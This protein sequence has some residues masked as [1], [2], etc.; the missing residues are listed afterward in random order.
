MSMRSGLTV[1]MAKSNRNRFM[2]GLLALPDGEIG[3]RVSSLVFS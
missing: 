3:V 1:T 2:L